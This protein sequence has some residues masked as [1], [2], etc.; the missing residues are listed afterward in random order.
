VPEN[1]WWKEYLE[2]IPGGYLDLLTAEEDAS[3]IAHFHPTLIPGLLQTERYA[4]AV[5]PV[6]TVKQ[7]TPFDAAALVHVR[8]LRQRAA[9]DESRPK[10][11]IF[12]MDETTLHRPIGPP[13][14]MREQ[15][16]HLLQIRER[17]SVNLV[18][19]PF[20]EQPHPGLL[21]AFM[22]LRYGGGINDIL[23]FEWQMGNTVVRDKPQLAER[24][25]ILV[26]RLC[27]RDP[28]GT[29]T[30]ARIEAALA[31]WS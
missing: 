16:R 22:H 9:L 8:I 13:S 12:L 7:V 26:E 30:M 23:C 20:R 25:R 17:P 28:D 15:L 1:G 5:T 6:T 29:G 18:V 4:V 11:L 14:V 3:R 21:G 2:V 31:G 27:E 19:L 24:Y 10:D